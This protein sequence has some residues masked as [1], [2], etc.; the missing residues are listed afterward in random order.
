MIM[1]GAVPRMHCRYV[2]QPITSSL[3]FQ[4]LSTMKPNSRRA[5]SVPF[6]GGVAVTQPRASSMHLVNLLV[7]NGGMLRQATGCF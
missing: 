6:D 5:C 1:Y 2:R 3:S 4:G 7:N